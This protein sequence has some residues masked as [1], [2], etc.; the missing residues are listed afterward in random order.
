MPDPAKMPIQAADLDKVRAYIRSLMAEKNVTTAKLAD[1]SGIA[2]G[3]LDNFFDGTT[4]APTFDKVAAIIMALEG[5]VDAA[6]GI[7]P[8]APA[9]PQTTDLDALLA[10]HQQTLDAKNE[11]IVALQEALAAERKKVKR[12]MLYQR[13]FIIENI[14]IVFVFLLDYYNHDWGYFRGSNLLNTF[15]Q[16]DGSRTPIFRG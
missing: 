2:K 9:A 16:R 5:S 7:R 11:F 10:S 13:L 15:F 12:F 3:T 6:L 4:K 8:P 1:I 14:I